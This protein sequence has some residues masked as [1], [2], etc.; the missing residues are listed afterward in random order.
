MSSSGMSKDSYCVLTYNNNNNNNNNKRIDRVSLVNVAV[1]AK[2]IYRLSVVSIKILISL[3]IKL[4]ERKSK[5][6]YRPR[7][8][9]K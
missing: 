8:V 4:G 5:N 9:H 6:S 7:K 2:V 3:S 1:F